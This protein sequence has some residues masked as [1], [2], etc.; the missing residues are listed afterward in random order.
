MSNVK[1]ILKEYAEIDDF[2]LTEAGIR[3]PKGT[4]AAKII[5]H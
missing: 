5:Y 4:H 2:L 3:I 1:D